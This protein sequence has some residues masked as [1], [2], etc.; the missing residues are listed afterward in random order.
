IHLLSNRNAQS[1]RFRMVHS[2]DVVISIEGETGTRSVLDV[3]LAIERPILPLPFGN[4]ISAKV[5]R[6]ER[7]EICEWF[8]ISPSE[9]EEFERIRLA[10]LSEAEIRA[11]AGR[12]C[13]CLMRGFT[14][15]CFV[16]MPFGKDHESVYDKAIRPALAAH[17]LQ[18]VRTDKHV[19]TG[20]VIAAIRD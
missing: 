18:P 14:R 16:I 11:L 20:N 10:D 17:G 8:Q 2:A 4:G 13:S 19:L 3:A 12:V 1:R 7:A 15:T 9:A 5:W 6:E